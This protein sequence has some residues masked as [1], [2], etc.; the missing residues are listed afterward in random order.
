[1]W[2]DPNDVGL[3]IKLLNASSINMNEF[4]RLAEELIY[5]AYLNKEDFNKRKQKVVLDKKSGKY[6]QIWYEWKKIPKRSEDNNR[7]LQV[8]KLK[9]AHR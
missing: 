9:L 3:D 5:Q 1:M 6:I 2:Y 7:F 8:R 4:R